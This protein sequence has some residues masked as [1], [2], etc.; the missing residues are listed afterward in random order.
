MAE[1]LSILEKLAVIVVAIVVV[2]QYWN[3]RRSKARGKQRG[4]DASAED[5]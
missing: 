4:G 2:H 3:Q 5:E 1:I